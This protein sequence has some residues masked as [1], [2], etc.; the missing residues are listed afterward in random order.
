[1]FRFYDGLD[2]F[3]TVRIIFWELNKTNINQ[4]YLQIV[5]VFLGPVTST[6]MC[7]IIQPYNVE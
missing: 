1:M 2:T 6:N 3:L 7:Y 4:T 5:K